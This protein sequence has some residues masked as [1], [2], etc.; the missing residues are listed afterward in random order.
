MKLLV[1]GHERES[2]DGATVRQLLI[3]ANLAGKPCAV[4]VNNALVPRSNH[5]VHV[6]QD[7]DRVEL[8]TLVGGG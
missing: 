4:E 2:P 8:V 3:D 6:L 1:N 5:E 7:G